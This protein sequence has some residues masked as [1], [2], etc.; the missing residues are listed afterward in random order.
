MKGTKI[1]RLIRQFTQEELKSFEKFLQSPYFNTNESVLKLY[2]YLLQFVPDFR[3]ESMSHEAAYAFIYPDKVFN[4]KGLNKLRAVLL[5]LTERFISIETLEQE[6]FTSTLYLLRFYEARILLV[7]FESQIKNSKKKLEKEKTKTTEYF[8]KQFLLA[9]EE[10]RF[11]AGRFQ[12][13]DYSVI[14]D[15][16]RYYCMEKIAYL[17]NAKN[18]ANIHAKPF[19]FTLSPQ[20]IFEGQEQV[21]FAA[22]QEALSLLSSEE[23]LPHFNHL[24][25]LLF[26]HPDLFS[27]ND[28]HNFCSYLQNHAIT[29]FSNKYECYLQL[30]ALYQFQLERGVFDDFNFNAELFR[31]VASVAVNLGELDWLE[32]LIVRFEQQILAFDNGLYEL[33]QARIHF[34]RQQYETSETYIWEA[35]SKANEVE[36]AFIYPLKIKLFYETNRDIEAIANSFKTFLHRLKSKLPKNHQYVVQRFRN[37]NNICTKIA[38]LNTSSSIEAQLKAISNLE[39]DLYDESKH[40]PEKEWLLKVLEL[41]LPRGVGIQLAEER[42]VLRKAKSSALLAD[43]EQFLTTHKNMMTEAQYQANFN[44]VRF[45]RAKELKNI[46]HE[47]FLAERQYFLGR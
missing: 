19:A 12:Q 16:D 4:Y 39:A 37:F 30:F 6:A 35:E 9:K 43:F 33:T 2:H 27:T 40:I 25:S 42:E 10:D 24:K 7:D 18:Y 22:W 17:T 1:V 47:E 34:N 44:F 31:N 8:Y 41:Q 46:C 20:A 13:F 32:Q 3:E 14:A 45:L 5:Q 26:E 29:L 11:R 21:S 23:K 15:L 38:K 28:L 36:K